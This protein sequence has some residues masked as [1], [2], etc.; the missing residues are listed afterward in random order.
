MFK[1]EWLFAASRGSIPVW[2]EPDP[3]LNPQATLD[4]MRQDVESRRKYLLN[5]SGARFPVAVSVSEGTTSRAVVIG[6]GSIF[7]DPNAR[8]GA[9]SEPPVDLVMSCLDWLR[10]RP[11]LNIVNKSYTGYKPNRAAEYSRMFWL[12]VGLVMLTIVGMGTIVWVVRR[13]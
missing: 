2:F 5:T 1:T 10:D 6:S 7:A 11:T 12:P 9:V 4:L 3:P 13:R 8:K